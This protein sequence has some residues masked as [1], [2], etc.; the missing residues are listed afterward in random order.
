M[1]VLKIIGYIVLALVALVLFP[2]LVTVPAS[3]WH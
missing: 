2:K 3:W 1:R